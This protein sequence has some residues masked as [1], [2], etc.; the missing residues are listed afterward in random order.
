M[1]KKYKTL[2]KLS[3]QSTTLNKVSKNKTKFNMNLNW[4]TL[5]EKLT[6]IKP[7]TGFKFFAGL[8]LIS[9]IIFAIFT[10]NRIMRVGF[11][12]KQATKYLSWSN[13]WNLSA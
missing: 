10:I 8:I 12:S 7:I 4:G 3:N 11:I 13:Q 2:S 5:K 9:G 1:S 6:T